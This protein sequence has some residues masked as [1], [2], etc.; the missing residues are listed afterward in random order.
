MFEKPFFGWFMGLLA[1]L[2]LVAYFVFDPEKNLFFPKCPVLA[3]TGYR[4]A[5]CGAQRAI[6]HLLH[7]QVG[8]AFAQN[9]LLVAS[10]PYLAVGFALE[11][12]PVRQR[13]PLLRKRFYGKK[14]AYVA[15]VV[16]IAF[17]VWRN[18]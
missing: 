2:L 1:V 9:P 6:H 17:M 15:F 7:L 3:L 4:C 14:A 8:P 10:I 11:W 13:F 5:G 12:P 18:L 16:I